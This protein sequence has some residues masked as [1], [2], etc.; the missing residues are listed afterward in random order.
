M[1]LHPMRLWLQCWVRAHHDNTHMQVLLWCGVPRVTFVI[2]VVCAILQG[3]PHR[4]HARCFCTLTKCVCLWSH[5]G[6][7]LG[8]PIAGTSASFGVIGPS[9][10][11]FRVQRVQF[12]DFANPAAWAVAS[13]SRCE[14]YAPGG[15]GFEV[16]FSIV[17]WTNSTNKVFW[18]WQNEGVVADKDGT[19]ALLTASPPFVASSR[20]IHALTHLPWGSGHTS[21]LC[22][23]H[24][25]LV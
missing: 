6:G 8:T 3:A 7:V 5:P 17:T 10:P 1:C 22:K 14:R 4:Q 11:G 25:A 21:I 19:Y 9:C 20:A 24:V 15:G 2:G 23:V 12:V 13:C 16:A 18:R